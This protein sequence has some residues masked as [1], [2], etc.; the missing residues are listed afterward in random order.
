VIVN[1]EAL[2]AGLLGLLSRSC[3]SMILLIY[4]G[5]R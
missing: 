3:Y 1:Q 4:L 5:R 2:G